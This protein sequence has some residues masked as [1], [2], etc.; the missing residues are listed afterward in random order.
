M[1]R[2]LIIGTSLI[3]LCI[4]TTVSFCE[5]PREHYLQ[6]NALK[7]Y[8]KS[9]LWS[10]N[11]VSRIVEDFNFCKREEIEEFSELDASKMEVIT[12][13]VGA[14]FANN[15]IH[16]CMMTKKGY[17]YIDVPACQRG[18]SYSDLDMSDVTTILPSQL[19]YLVT[20]EGQ[21]FM[22]IAKR[23][24]L[25]RLFKEAKIMDKEIDVGSESLFDKEQARLSW[26]RFERGET[27]LDL[28]SFLVGDVFQVEVKEPRE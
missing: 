15:A 23:D 14:G 9:G 27:P 22:G 26:Q 19:C 7:T 21:S 1:K 16:G 25:D 6:G 28:S 24:A 8:Y 3:F 4:E 5:T 13:G 11:F 20:E 18:I 10:K 17:E 12:F 2:I